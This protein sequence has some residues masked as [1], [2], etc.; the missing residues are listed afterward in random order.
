MDILCV[1]ETRWKREKAG[2]IGGGYKMWY[3]GS[4]NKKNGVRIIMEK[5]HVDKV[6][7]FWRVTDKI[8]CLKMKLD[9]VMLNVISVYAP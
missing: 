4:R 3:C 2:C 7:E 1:Q 9:V 6:V 8:I 5:E